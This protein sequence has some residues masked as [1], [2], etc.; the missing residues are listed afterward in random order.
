MI[1]HS[2]TNSAAWQ[3][4][5][6]IWTFLLQFANDKIICWQGALWTSAL[7]AGSSQQQF[8]CPHSRLVTPPGQ[9]LFYPIYLEN[10]CALYRA[11][12]TST[13][14]RQQAYTHNLFDERKERNKEPVASCRFVVELLPDFR[15]VTPV[16]TPSVIRC[17]NGC[18]SSARCSVLTAG[19]TPWSFHN[20]QFLWSSPDLCL[21]AIY[22]TVQ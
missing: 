21:V 7:P 22:S 3:K 1:F 5:Q 9:T 11:D 13:P 2:D 18:A 15:S 12:P 14:H 10:T 6:T 20:W 16:M 8:F 17:S 19:E 4:I